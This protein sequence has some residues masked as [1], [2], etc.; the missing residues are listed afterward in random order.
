M[1]YIPEKTK[2]QVRSVQ[3]FAANEYNIEFVRKTRIMDVYNLYYMHI[4]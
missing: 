3:L 4:C 1:N 2:M